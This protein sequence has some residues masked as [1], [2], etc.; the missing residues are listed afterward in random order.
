MASEVK[1][2]TSG[3]APVRVGGIATGAV[4]RNP[5][6]RWADDARRLAT[7][8]GGA[9]VWPELANEGAVEGVW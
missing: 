6:E 2:P 7:Q 8:G 9:L 5:R 3:G 1:L 4:L